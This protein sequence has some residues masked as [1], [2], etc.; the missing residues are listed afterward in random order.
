MPRTTHAQ[1]I[2][3]LKAAMV[4]MAG[5]VDTLARTFAH[6][7]DTSG[8]EPTRAAKR[9]KPTGRGGHTAHCTDA[10]TLH[11]GRKAPAVAVVT[12]DGAAAPRTAELAEEISQVPMTREEK[13]A[14]PTWCARVLASTRKRH[15][16]FAVAVTSSERERGKALR[17]LDRMDKIQSRVSDPVAQMR[18]WL[19]PREFFAAHSEIAAAP[20]R[21]KRRAV[22]TAAEVMAERPDANAAM[23]KA[24]TDAVAVSVAQA[25]KAAIG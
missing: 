10:C 19:N 5:T 24:I 17:L 14:D 18:A 3:E 9:V 20:V 8:P 16:G 23:V 25:I 15:E 6:L 13:L 12:G 11:K 7:R 1:E 22:V 4:A 21:V 2:A